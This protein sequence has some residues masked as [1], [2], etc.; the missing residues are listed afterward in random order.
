MIARPIAGLG[1]AVPRPTAGVIV[2]GTRRNGAPAGAA[3]SADTRRIVG[4]DVAVMRR[5]VTGAG[6]H[7][8]GV[9][10]RRVVTIAGLRRDVV[11]GGAVIR[12]IAGRGAA[13]RPIA[14]VTRGIAMDT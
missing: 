4:A 11:P 2:V 3:T 6:L 7:K 13:S 12:T 10:T 9:V 1:A 8:A 5:T 14:V